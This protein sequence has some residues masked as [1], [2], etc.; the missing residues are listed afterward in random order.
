MTISALDFDP[1][2]EAVLS[3]PFPHHERLREAGPVVWLERYQ[4]YGLARF[5]EVRD[6]LNDWE[7]FVSSRGVGL[8]DFATEQPWRPPSLLLEADP[9]LH[10]R[11]RG[12]MNK[13]A[14]LPSLKARQPE[15]RTKATA[16]VRELVGRG[17]VEAVADL[18]EAFPLSIFPD[19]IGLRD[20]GRENLIPYATT[21]FNAFGPRNALLEQ[22]MSQAVAATAWVAESCKR[23]FLKPDG[24][25]REVYAAADRG[26]CSEDEAQR[27]VRSFLSAG[28]DTTVNGIANLVFA[29]TQFPDEWRKLKEKPELCRKAIEESLRWGGVAQTFYRTTSCDADVSGTTIPEG[30]KVLLFLASA[31]RDPRR[32]DD[33]DRF[34]IDRNAS[35]HVGFGFGIHQC[36]GQMVARYE[37]EAVLTALVEQVAEI[38]AAGPATRRP[39]NTLYAL[40]TLPVELVAA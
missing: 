23:E 2:D 12:L 37:A 31:N 8:A 18:S 32:W 38:R 15:W 39:N 40:D 4:C 14:S 6:A 7:T 19:M 13:V 22:S 27:L 17:A 25:G 21:V 1:Y 11:T 5:A 9:P 26:D 10:S 36:L 3:D 29:F 20:E 34:D 16:L 28:V 30:S 35:G 33:P 24:W